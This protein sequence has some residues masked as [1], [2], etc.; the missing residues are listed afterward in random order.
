AALAFGAL[1]GNAVAQSFPERSIEFVVPYPPG[2]SVDMQARMLQNTMSEVLGETVVVENRP[3]AGSNIGA[4][5]V[6]RSEPDGHR[7][8]MATNATLAINPHVYQQIGYEVGDLTPVT[9]LSSSPLAIG[10]NSNLG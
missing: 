1:A 3:G 2:A 5:Y 6:A 4:A 8:L 7:I 10:I 9:Y